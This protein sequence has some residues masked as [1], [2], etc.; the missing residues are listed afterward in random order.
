ML[1]IFLV[2]LVFQI[3]SASIALANDLFEWEFIRKIL[4][5]PLFLIS[6]VIE[7]ILVLRYINKKL[8]SGETIKTRTFYLVSLL[9]ISFPTI[10]FTVG[11]IIVTDSGI[12]SAY[13]ILNSPPEFL[14]FIFLIT[15]SFLLNS[16]LCIT[17]GVVA[18]IEYLL[19]CIFFLGDG[20]MKEFMLSATK[21]LLLLGTGILTGVISGTIRKSVIESLEAQR[22]MIEDLDIKVKERTS[23][24]N[25][26]KEIV[27]E[28]NKEI[29]DSI[30]Y[31]KRI[32]Y[33]LLAHQE[34]LDKNLPEH[35]VLF[36]PKDIV[37]GD[38]YWATKNQ[39][40]DFYLAVC[41]STGHGVPGAFMSLLNIS[42]LNEAI[43]EKNI[44]E[45]HQVLNHVRSRLIQN[46]ENSQDGMDATLIRFMNGK[47]QYASAHN[48]PLLIRNGEIKELHA[49]KMPVGKGE[50]ND[51]FTLH[52][53]DLQKND[54]LF[55]FTDGYADQFGGPKGKKFKYS[56]LQ[57]LF[58][59][60]ADKDLD[61]QSQILNQK[62]QEWKGDLE[63]VDDVCI[64]GIRI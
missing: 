20:D 11:T 42:F 40:G 46:M 4:F 55:F 61:S 62:F 57:K 13:M 50:K 15:S 38:F 18:A 14:Y 21:S 27:E 34:L 24:L 3:T 22:A 25:L 52:E 28:K 37:S 58:F 6:V 51:S 19:L 39:N 54:L 31:A 10:V 16:A 41:D 26:Q 60:N 47:I 43:S 63:Q 8:E 17:L 2:V 33:T 30:N 9:E 1:V 53:M 5:V 48:H 56:N 64:I 45:P 29:I 23:E 7:E 44:S 49:D 35:F 32:Q 12:A 36:K 59:E